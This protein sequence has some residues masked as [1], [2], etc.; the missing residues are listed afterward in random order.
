MRR[1]LTEIEVARKMNEF[2]D[3]MEGWDPQCVREAY[4]ILKSW[5]RSKAR[6]Q[7]ADFSEGDRVTFDSGRVREGA[8]SIRHG[9]VTRVHLTRVSVKVEG[10]YGKWRVPCSLIIDHEVGE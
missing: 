10:E 3:S 1:V 5:E 9:I 7:I 8:R 4:R 6:E 2:E